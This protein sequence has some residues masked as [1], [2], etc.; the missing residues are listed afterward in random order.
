MVYSRRFS[1][2]ALTFTPEINNS[3]FNL[4]SNSIRFHVLNDYLNWY[5]SYLRLSVPFVTYFSIL[6]FLDLIWNLHV[7]SLVWKV[8]SKHIKHKS[9]RIKCVIAVKSKDSYLFKLDL[10]N[11]TIFVN[12]SYRKGECLR[13]WKLRM[14]LS[15]ISG[16]RSFHWLWTSFSRAFSR[17]SLSPG[18]SR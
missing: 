5:H 10:N 3:V 13:I 6:P 2:D 11:F 16:M 7:S 15:S 17:F 18:C 12:S 4:L 8:L 9:H 14:S 1:C